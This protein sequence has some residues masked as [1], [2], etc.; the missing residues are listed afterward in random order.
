MGKIAAFNWQILRQNKSK[1]TR[2]RSK[3]GIVVAIVGYQQFIRRNFYEQYAG[4]HTKSAGFLFLV[5]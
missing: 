1:D 4:Q 3:G 2:R 5:L